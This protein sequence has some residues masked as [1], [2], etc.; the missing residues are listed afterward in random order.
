[1]LIIG[2]GGLASDILSS[3]QFDDGSDDLCFYNDTESSPKEYIGLNYPV[4]TSFAEARAYF[5]KD[6][7]FIVAVGNNL[8]RKELIEKFQSIGG[9]NVNYISSRALVGRNVKIGSHGVVIMHHAIVGNGCEVGNGSIV[10]VNSS[11]GHESILHE[12]V[13]VSGQVCMSNTVIESYTM[14]GIG[15][16]FKPGITVGTNCIIGVGS[17]VINNVPAGNIVAGNPARIIKQNEG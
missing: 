15:A 12:F 17:V 8:Y 13:L 4:I 16:V 11:L 7:R 10:Y 6:Q 5:E 2:T 1:M 3:M 9:I 14:I